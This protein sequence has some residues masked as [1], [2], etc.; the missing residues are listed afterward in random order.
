MAGLEHKPSSFAG[1]KKIGSALTYIYIDT[2][3]HK[4]QVFINGTKV[5]EWS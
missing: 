3:N 1:N 2:I 4:I 5:H